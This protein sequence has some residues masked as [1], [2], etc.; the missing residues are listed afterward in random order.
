MMWVSENRSSLKSQ[1]LY[2]TES[3]PPYSERA[4]NTNKKKLNA[5][6]YL[7]VFCIECYS[8]VLNNSELF[9]AS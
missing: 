3:K 2:G 8:H 4:S 5:L 9:P 6:H 7:R 1:G